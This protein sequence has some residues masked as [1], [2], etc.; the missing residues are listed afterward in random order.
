MAVI[1]GALMA[2]SAIVALRRLRESLE[3]VTKD[4]AINRH[5]ENKD[6]GGDNAET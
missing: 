2:V 4:I 6:K 3:T 5:R 1:A